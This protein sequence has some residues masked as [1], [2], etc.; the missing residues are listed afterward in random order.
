MCKILQ[1]LDLAGT[2][3]QTQ[4]TSPRVMAYLANTLWDNEKIET[5]IAF[6]A[7]NR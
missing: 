4:I 6:G 7:G 2:V 5:L 3:A 1:D